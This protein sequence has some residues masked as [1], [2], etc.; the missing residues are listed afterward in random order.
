MK[1]IPQRCFITVRTV[2]KGKETDELHVVGHIDDILKNLTASYKMMTELLELEEP[3]NT[4]ADIRQFVPFDMRIIVRG[5]KIVMMEIPEEKKKDN[6]P[7]TSGVQDNRSSTNDVQNNQKMTSTPSNP[8]SSST[9]GF[10]DAELANIPLP[11]YSQYDEA[12]KDHSFIAGRYGTPL[13]ITFTPSPVRSTPEVKDMKMTQKMNG[14]DDKK[15]PTGFTNGVPNSQQKME[16]SSVMKMGTDE[17]KKSGDHTKDMKC[18]PTDKKK[19]TSTMKK[20]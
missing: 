2:G 13:K 7:S 1:T 15:T 19:N 18:K 6:E 20:Y 4:I 17:T 5:V 16:K 14:T 11:D 8:P 12:N 10:T 3:E 9:S